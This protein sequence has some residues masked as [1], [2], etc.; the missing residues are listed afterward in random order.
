MVD[1]GGIV[2][3]WSAKSI[4]SSILVANKAKPTSAS[5]ESTFLSIDSNPWKP[6]IKSILLS[7]L[8]SPPPKIG[9]S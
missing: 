1:L 4:T 9:S 5:P 7:Y 2:N 6:A 3:F 8:G